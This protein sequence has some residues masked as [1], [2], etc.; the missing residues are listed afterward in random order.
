MWACQKGACAVQKTMIRIILRWAWAMPLFL[1]MQL[2]TTQTN[3]IEAR[4]ICSF[5]FAQN[6]ERLA[7]VF[8]LLVV[9]ACAVEIASYYRGRRARL[10][11]TRQ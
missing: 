11:L 8:L 2:A 10:P 4:I 7:L 6:R 5:P 1:Y 3:C 9:C